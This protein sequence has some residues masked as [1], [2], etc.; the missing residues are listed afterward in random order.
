MEASLL[1]QGFF[2]CILNVDKK[3]KVATIHH[4]PIR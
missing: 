2:F 4:V 1:L 3:M